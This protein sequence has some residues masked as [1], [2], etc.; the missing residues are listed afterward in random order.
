MTTTLT[1]FDFDGSRGL[2]CRLAL[3]VAGVPF[4]DDRIA[5]ER[6]RELKPSVPFSGLPVLTHQGRTLSQS[7]AILNYIGRGHGLYPTDPWIAAE[8]DALMHSVEDLRSKVPG[9]RGMPEDEK[10]AA[11]EAFA[12]GWLTRWATTTS[13]RIQGPFLEG[14][15]LHVADLKLFVVLR[16][17]LAGGYDF[18]PAS[19]FD[20][21][22]ALTEFVAAVQAHPPVAAYFAARS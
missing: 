8:H 18:I 13:A 20:A 1:Y 2:E 12:A 7:T 16:A 22:P 19:F 14:A 6:W 17:Y 3:H 21:Y 10:K 4:T 5:R 15:E 11:R 9:S